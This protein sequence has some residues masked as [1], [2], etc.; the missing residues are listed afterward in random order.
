MSASLPNH[1]FQEA[2]QWDERAFQE[3]HCQSAVVS[4]RLNPR[5][6]TGHPEFEMTPVPWC[7][8]GYYLPERPRFTLDPLFHAGSYYVQ[9]ASSMFVQYALQQLLPPEEQPLKVLDLCAAPGGKST[10]LASCLR[11]DDLLISNEVIPSRC[12]V[13]AENMSRWGYMNTWVTQNDPAAFGSLPAYFDALLIDAPCTGSGLWRKDVNAIDEWSQEQVRFCSERQKRV[14][15]DALPALKDEGLLLYATCSFS[16][17]ENESVSDWICHEFDVESLSVILPEDWGITQTISPE[18]KATGYRFYPWKLQGE[19]FFLAAFRVRNRKVVVNR[20]PWKNHKAAASLQ[21]AWKDWLD[22]DFTVLEK[23]G[24]SIA[25][26]PEHVKEQEFLS[27]FLRLKK[28]GTL[29]GKILP[30]ENIP[31]HELAMSI[32][33]SSNLPKLDV[34]KAEAL[35]YLKKEAIREEHPQRGWQTVCYQGLALGWGKWLGNRMN[36]Y[37]PKNLR[38]RMDVE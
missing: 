27:Q 24:N 34:S 9:E 7:D 26:H 30:K 36:N 16:P 4:I 22:T 17:E 12:A 8:T 32:H 19:G 2:P 31:E 13:L 29:L 35:H 1:T 6:Q 23:Q 33:L 28:S 21:Q 5:K 18:H 11:P 37:L 15:A 20:R 10:L 14:I 3:A 38:I 25:V